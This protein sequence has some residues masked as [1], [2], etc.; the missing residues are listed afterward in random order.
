MGASQIRL[1]PLFF[2]VGVNSGISFSSTTGKRA[3]TLRKWPP[4]RLK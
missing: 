3:P 1:M 4:Q 2:P